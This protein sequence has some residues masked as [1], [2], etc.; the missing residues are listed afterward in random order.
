[1]DKKLTERLQRWLRQPA[2]ERSLAEGGELVRIFLHN[3]VLAQT[4]ERKRSPLAMPAVEEALW[5]ILTLR[6][7]D[8]THEEVQRM[9]Q[10]AK[11]IVK[12]AADKAPGKKTDGEQEPAAYGKRADHDQL[13][14]DIQTLYVRN[15]DLRQRI[16]H[17]HDMLLVIDERQRKTPGVCSDGEAY[18]ILKEIIEADKDYHRNWQQYDRYQISV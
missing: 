9:R 12:E 8:I 17:L 2:A 5:R 6:L 14:E 18:P 16:R 15:L 4:L 10:Q 11:Q 3:P 1:M 13:P 7:N